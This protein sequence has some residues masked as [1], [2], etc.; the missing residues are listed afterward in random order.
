[1]ASGATPKTFGETHGFNFAEHQ[2]HGRPPT[3]KKNL[4]LVL[5]YRHA[6]EMVP[7][8]LSGGCSIQTRAG[9]SDW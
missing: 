4:R 6:Q 2:W 8:H 5:L 3:G 9:D 1:M 7:R